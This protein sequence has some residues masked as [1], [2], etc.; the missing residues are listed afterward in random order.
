MFTAEVL[1]MSF[2][3]R[4]LPLAVALVLALAIPASAA[5]DPPSGRVQTD[6]GYTE[7]LD[8]PVRVGERVELPEGWYRV[9][10]AGP[11]DRRV[12]SFSVVSSRVLAATAGAPAPIEAEAAAPG[13]RKPG[14]AGCRDERSA[15]L[16]EYLKAQ[17]VEVKDP[18]GFLQ[19]LEGE[20]FARGFAT[21]WMTL[22]GDPVRATAWSSELRARADA[23]ARCARGG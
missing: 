21:L 3:P 11:E 9:E 5:A 8:R 1:Q 18:A 6:E 10:E 15:F 12:G 20:N 22:N 13:E 19:A 4:A 16:S 17:G 23:L 2:P 14:D 7:I